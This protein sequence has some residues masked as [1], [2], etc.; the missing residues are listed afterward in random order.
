MKVT[1]VEKKNETTI[2]S[3]RIY[4]NRKQFFVE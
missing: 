1:E 3:N 2:V 4:T